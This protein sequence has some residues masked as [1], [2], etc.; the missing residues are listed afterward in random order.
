M[1]CQQDDNLSCKIEVV[2][3]NKVETNMH[4][5][6]INIYLKGRLAFKLLQHDLKTTTNWLT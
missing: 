2:S 1:S 4:V 6:Y 5:D 3:E